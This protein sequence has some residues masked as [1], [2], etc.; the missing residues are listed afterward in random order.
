M[1]EIGA[2]MDW[3]TGGTGP[4]LVFAVPDVDVLGLFVLEVG[5]VWVDSTDSEGI[6]AGFQGFG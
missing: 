3:E 4:T 5:G 6:I 2:E 1:F